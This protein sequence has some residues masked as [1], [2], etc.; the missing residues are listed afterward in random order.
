MHYYSIKLLNKKLPSYIHLFFQY[1]SRMKDVSLEQSCH[2][3]K[4]ILIHLYVQIFRL[5]LFH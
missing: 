3:E 1:N 2:L 5:N 4:L